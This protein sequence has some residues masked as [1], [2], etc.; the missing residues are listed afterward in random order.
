MF[1][2]LVGMVLFSGAVY[3][4]YRS[5][6]AD[7]A[8][9]MEAIG[10]AGAK[11]KSTRRGETAEGLAYWERLLSRGTLAG[12]EAEIW[13]RQ[14]RR[15]VDVRFRKSRGSILTVLELKP[16]RPPVHEFRLQ[17]V[18]VM[19]WI[20]QFTRGSSEP[21][22]TGDAAFDDAFKL[23]AN[24]GAGALAVLTPELRREILE[25]RDAVAGDV[26][27]LRSS[28]QAAGLLLGSFEIGPARVALGLF[29]TPSRK[30]GEQL[31]RAAPIL[32]RLCAYGRR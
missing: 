14:I 3:W 13:E 12:C 26:A 32:A 28:N 1:G 19:G 22:A 6:Q 30:I 11:E 21:V 24:D 23:Y 7:V 27:Q 9:C 20:E 2:F 8:A 4:L 10:F 17:P 5:K 15:A 31:R 25:F 18:G 16:T 29:G